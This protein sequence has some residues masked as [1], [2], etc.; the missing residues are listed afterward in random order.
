MKDESCNRRCATDRFR[1]RCKRKDPLRQLHLSSSLRLDSNGIRN[2]QREFSRILSY[3]N[4]HPAFY[5]DNGWD[6]GVLFGR[7]T[8]SRNQIKLTIYFPFNRALLPEV[9]F[10]KFST[11]HRHDFH[12]RHV[13]FLTDTDNGDFTQTH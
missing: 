6:A 11:T 10:E 8:F 2:E 4:N 5:P 12:S 13:R 9:R 7:M 1:S 3:G